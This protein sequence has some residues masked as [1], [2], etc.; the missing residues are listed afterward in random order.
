MEAREFTRKLNKS[1]PDA[2]IEAQLDARGILTLKGSCESWQE[3]VRIGHKAAKLPGVKNVVNE[4]EAKGVQVPKKNYAA[5]CARG[6]TAG[7]IGEADV[8]IVGAGISGCG[9]ARELAKHNWNIVVIDMADDVAMGATKAN[10]GNIHPG[11]SVKPGTLKAKLNVEGNRLY[12]RWAEELDFELQRCGAMGFVTNRPLKAALKYAYRQAIKNGVDG[13]V[14]V[15]GKRA[16]E[17]EPGLLKNGLGNKV[18]AALWLPS[19]G[20]VEP[21]QVALALA[22]NAAQNGVR[23][24]L[25]TT[26]AGILSE[27]RAVSGVVT[28]RG[29]VRARCV[30]NCAGVYADEISALAGDKSYTIHARRGVI[31][32]LDKAAQPEYRSLCEQVTFAEVKR[33]FQHSE[34]KGGGMCR[35][36]EG[37]VLM[38]PSALEIPDKEDLSTTMEELQYAMGR[39]DGTISYGNII[40]FF[41]GNRPADYKEDFVIEMSPVTGGFVNVGAIQSPGLAA[42]PAIAHMVEGIVT[43]YAKKVGLSAEIKADWQPRRT[44][45]PE[46]RHMSREQQ[47]A[48]IRENPAYGKIVCRC[49][50]ITEGEIVDALR[51]PV[52]P[53]SIDA[54]K[55]RTRAGMG[56]CQ[57]GF[58]QPRVLELMA[59]E[60]GETW[61]DITLKGPDT[62]VLG[63]RNRGEEDDV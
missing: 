59:R 40:R 37:N 49:E 10:N 56:R 30:V 15:D 23:F 31:A 46:F 34:T 33:A 11:H 54:V 19:M 7:V 17:L 26:V 12:D 21:Y 25:N 14:L 35:T 60:L 38:G 5:L 2:A 32:I 4:L 44:R 27:N 48:L 6:E 36:P 22:E 62:Q 47:D 53:V 63:R 43:E 28:D 55:R 24:M 20:L 58:C 45:R 61:T 1:F 50:S 13:A 51:S 29:V 16:C 41:A 8:V 52:P 39:G 9:I 18:K 3:L 57:G 42:A